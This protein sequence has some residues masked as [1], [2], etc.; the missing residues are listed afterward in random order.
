MMKALVH[1][2]PGHMAWKGRAGAARAQAIEFI[3]EAA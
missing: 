2:G 3:V 1:Q